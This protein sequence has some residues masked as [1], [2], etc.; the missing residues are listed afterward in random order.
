MLRLEGELRRLVCGARGTIAREPWYPRGNCAAESHVTSPHATFLSDV[1]RGARGRWIWEVDGAAKQDV[2][3]MPQ[4]PS[5]VL[6]QRRPST[7]TLGNNACPAATQ[8]A[9]SGLP[10]S[11]LKAEATS[12]L[13]PRARHHFHCN[14]WESRKLRSGPS[15]V[16]PHPAPCSPVSLTVS[17]GDTPW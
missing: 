6:H 11:P 14:S 4:V 9:R 15:R 16:L 12:L 2:V 7:R 10:P 17:A 13:L 5:M 1:D 8:R 3:T